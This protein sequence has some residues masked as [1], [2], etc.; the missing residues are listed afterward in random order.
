MLRLAVP[1][2]LFQTPFGAASR[3][4]LLD[5]VDSETHEPVSGV[6]LSNCKTRYSLTC[7]KVCWR[8]AVE[9]CGLEVGSNPK[10]G[11]QTAG[12]DLKNKKSKKCNVASYSRAG[13][14]MHLCCRRSSKQLMST[15]Q[16]LWS[17]SAHYHHTAA[18]TISMR[19][20]SVAFVRQG[21]RK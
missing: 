17:S 7:W 16:S 11:P 1:V 9:L 3:K 5:R 2:F 20:K 4:R 18:C 6:Y 10:S 14:F 8:C 12:W 21:P 19:K 13:M 15:R